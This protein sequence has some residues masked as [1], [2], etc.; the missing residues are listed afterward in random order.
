M[1]LRHQISL[2]HAAPS[3]LMGVEFILR[4][5]IATARFYATSQIDQSKL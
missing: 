5:P 1:L 4:S 3:M 2:S